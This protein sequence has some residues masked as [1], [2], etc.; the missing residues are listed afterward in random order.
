MLCADVLTGKLRWA[1][2]RVKDYGTTVPPWYTGQCPL[3]DGNRVILAPGGTNT[4][5]MAVDL[6]S[7]QVLWRTPNPR[8]WKM[9]HS[10]VMPVDVAGRRMF[11]YCAS[12]GV[13][14]VSAQDGAI[15][16]DTTDWKISL[17]TVPC[18]LDLGQG[19][20]FL[21]GGYNAGSLVLQLKEDG[22]RLTAEIALRLSSTGQGGGV[23]WPRVVGSDG[24]RRRP[25]DRAGF[26]SDGL[27]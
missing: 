9:T 6:S 27:P 1:I 16:W 12:G 13:L 25:S 19:R 20:I 26:A 21:T 2:D 10:S 18:P 22:P 14:G 11:V 24:F 5:L 4:F 17:A 8:A 15:L 23:G 7:G 3:L